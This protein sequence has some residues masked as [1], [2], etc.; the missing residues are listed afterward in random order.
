MVIPVEGEGR[1][2]G[3]WKESRWLGEVN[4]TSGEGYET[5][6]E[7]KKKFKGSNGLPFFWFIKN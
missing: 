6:N 4:K 2:S 3:V 5:I 7:D 1:K